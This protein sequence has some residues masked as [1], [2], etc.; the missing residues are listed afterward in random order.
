MNEESLFHEALARPTPRERA[1]FLDA[2]CAGRPE[3]RAAVEALLSAHDRPGEFLSAPPALVDAGG[4]ET[5]N[6]PVSTDPDTGPPAAPPTVSYDH[7]ATTPPTPADLPGRIGRYE[8]RAPLGRGGMGTVYLA[9][10]PELDRPVALKVPQV[11][12][13]AAVERFL[14]EAR[15]AAALD[16]PNLCRVYDAGRADG[17]LYLAMAYV[18]GRT[19]AEVVRRNGPLPPERAAAVAAGVA[20]GMA[21]AH[22]HGIVHRDLKPGNV[23]FDRHGEPVVTDFG[24]ARRAG[25]DDAPPATPDAAARP[26]HRL[27]QTGALMGTPA[28]MSPEQARGEHGAVGSAADVYALGAILFE[29]L[30]GRPPFKGDS[31]GQTLRM[32]ETEPVPPMPGAPAALEAVCLRALAKDPAA[33]FPSMGA[34]A[35]ALAAF[36]DARR[37]R[38]RRRALLAAAAAALLLAAGTVIYVKTDNGTVEVRLNDPTADVRVSVDGNEITLAEGGRTTRLRAGAHELE[39]R[40]PDYETQARLFKVTRGERTLVEVELRPKQDAGP[41]AKSPRSAG[42]SAPPPD[43]ARLAALLAR[44]RRLYDDGRFGEVGPLADEALGID[45]ESPGALAL[46]G[47]VRFLRGDRAGARADAEAALRLNPETARG[48]IVRAVL[49]GVEG[50]SDEAIA[51]ATAA[52]RLEPR[53]PVPWS[54]RARAYMDKKEFRQAAADA[55]R[56]IEFRFLGPDPLMNRAAAHV[57][58]GEYA[59][60]LADLDAAVAVLPHN[61]QV[62]AQRSAVHARLG[63][64]T[65]AAADW[66]TAR[67]LAQAIGDDDRPA[68]PDPPRPPARKKLTPEE[69]AMVDR[70]VAAARVAYAG[71]RFEDALRAADEAV[72]IDPTSAPAR[73]ARADALVKLRQ[74]GKAEEDASA[75]VRL[76]PNAPRV[77]IARGEVRRVGGSPAAA[78]A[79]FTIALTLAPHNADAWNNRGYAFHL[80]GQHHQ[81]VADLT[82]AIRLGPEATFYGNRGLCYVHLGEYQKALADY[83]AAAE[84][85]PLNPRWRMNCAVLKSRLGDPEGAKLDREAARTIEPSVTEIALPSVPP[86]KKDPEQP[87]DANPGR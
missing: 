77:Y 82:E 23:L 87:A 1:A 32:I 2:A 31:V 57:N 49:A 25:D 29:L 7:L 13:P 79:D 84:R 17:V 50:R 78:I 39:V 68:L 56:A 59:R 18:P 75:A 37:R 72:A 24:L 20:R 66:A 4:P 36:A 74:Y 80:R 76:E 30:T 83:A 64:A 86:V 53:H 3:L 28:Y 48:L 9:H 40:G 10:D 85:E 21:E 67:K 33:R 51:D 63:N 47:S 12:G 6:Y 42:P 34:F 35:D 27:T 22:S 19:L 73:V 71:Q 41:V 61:P 14:R 55:G 46:R 54:L 62:F 5:E 69:A 52:A 60:A 43:R 58:L 8:I 81:S 45:P 15:A 65:K 11:S 26:T 44:G 16:H 70:A 38:R